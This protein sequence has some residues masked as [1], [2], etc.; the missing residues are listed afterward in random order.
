M[1]FSSSNLHSITLGSLL[2]Q[3]KISIT[4][5]SLVSSHVTLCMTC[6]D[7]AQQFRSPNAAGDEKAASRAHS[8][9]GPKSPVGAQA[10]PELPA[11]A[12][13]CS[14]LSGSECAATRVAA[15][16]PHVDPLAGAAPAA[17]A[18][19]SVVSPRTVAAT[20]VGISVRSPDRNVSTPDGE[21]G[22]LHRRSGSSEQCRPDG[23][24]EV[25]LALRQTDIDA[26]CAAPA[27]C[28]PS[29]SLP[30][31]AP[32]LSVPLWA[33]PG[34][35]PHPPSAPGGSPQDGSP[36]Q[37]HRGN[38]AAAV[39]AVRRLDTSTILQQAAAL[40]TNAVGNRL[41]D[42]APS[43]LLAM[44]KQA[45]QYDQQ[46]GPTLGPQPASGAGMRLPD[47]GGLR[48]RAE[49]ALAQLLPPRREDASLVH[50][51]FSR[52]GGANPLA[53][54]HLQ[55]QLAAAQQHPRH[56]EQLLATHTDRTGPA[57]HHQYHPHAAA[58]QAYAA[59][60]G[61]PSVRSG[62]Q[63]TSMP[64]LSGGAAEHSG[65]RVVSGNEAASHGAAPD[66][67]RAAVGSA[68]T[69]TLQDMQQVAA[70][71]V[72]Q[73]REAMVQQ[74]SPRRFTLPAP[75]EGAPHTCAPQPT[76]DASR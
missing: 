61:A 75:G 39:A 19:D 2:A 20:L 27:G 50:D 49:Q 24:T 72:Q 13:S 36:T 57:S 10:S 15:D 33:P 67:D 31:A 56:L 76:R 54:L 44:H 3:M 12:V 55:Q 29:S 9:A 11:H 38:Y 59:G 18:A 16:S 22:S 42:L 60:H 6:R 70:A 73:H 35:L 62:L 64:A 7:M 69:V 68:Q 32:T 53:L 8:A 63:A 14:S 47:F 45:Q 17:A 48:S 37:Q 5:Q 40:T 23:T 25:A 21:R 74:A 65:R 26:P 51:L 43:E 52:G 66:D 71:L 1:Q 34:S 41:W 58:S 4:S 28:R 30:A 46:H